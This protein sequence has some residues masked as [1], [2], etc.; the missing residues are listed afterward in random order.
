MDCYNSTVMTALRQ[1][2]SLAKLHLMTTLHKC[3]LY[4]WLLT[5]DT[6]FCQTSSFLI[7][8]YFHFWK[9]D[10]CYLWDSFLTILRVLYTTRHKKEKRNTQ[11][12][13]VLLQLNNDI[14]GLN[15]LYYKY[16]LCTNTMFWI[17]WHQH[18][19][20]FIQ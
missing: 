19:T 15:T 2:N 3:N 9:V 14:K 20:K 5:H 16:L 12:V 10:L 1:L 8:C 4:S 6:L 13:H 17:Y 18:T 11:A 7:M